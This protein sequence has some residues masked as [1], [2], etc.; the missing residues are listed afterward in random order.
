MAWDPSALF[1]EITF[2]SPPIPS[3]PQPFFPPSSQHTISSPKSPYNIKVLAT[4][5]HNPPTFEEQIGKLCIHASPWGQGNCHQGPKLRKQ[6]VL[7]LHN[8]PH[9]L[10]LKS[11]LLLT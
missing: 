4:N 1:S 9:H 10:P 11:K 5:A 8:I 7:L 3:A 6:T 2:P